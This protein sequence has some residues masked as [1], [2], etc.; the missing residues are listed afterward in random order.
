ME[1]EIHKNNMNDFLIVY[2][3][4][5]IINND[6]MSWFMEELKIMYDNENIYI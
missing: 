3:K 2:L 6:A 1:E 4:A 5:I